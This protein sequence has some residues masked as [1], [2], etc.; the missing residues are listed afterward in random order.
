MSVAEKVDLVQAVQSDIG[1]QRA[2]SLVGLA[3]STWYYREKER[4]CSYEDKYGHL[5]GPL[6]EIAKRHPEYGYRRATEELRENY[7]ER[8]G[9]K[10]VQRLNR[11]WGLAILRG[12]KPPRPSVIRR[13]ITEVGG[14]ANLVKDLEE[15]APFEVVY[16]DFTDIVYARGTAKLI[17]I[18]DHASKA[19]LGWA[20]EEQAVT[21]TA[22][23]AWTMARRTLARFSRSAKGVIVHHDQDPVFTSH[24]WV[25]RL[26]VEDGAHISYALNGAKDNPEMESFFSRFKSE[27]RS[28]FADAGDVDALKAIVAERMRYYTRER[29]HSVLGNVAPLTFVRR[30]KKKK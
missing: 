24:A 15:I 21:R 16:T 20:L 7:G 1:L 10:V 22:L 18:V 28:L 4:R 6:E 8:A 27:N 12:V 30:L 2:L 19:S 3:R 25:R 9:K 17:A 23:K 29:R 13:M 5:R 26:L 14:R 11:M